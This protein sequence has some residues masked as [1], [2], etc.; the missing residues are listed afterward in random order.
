M[1]YATMLENLTA[2]EEGP[3]AVE[4]LRE[5][6]FIE[7]IIDGKTGASAAKDAGYGIAAQRTPGKLLESPELRERYQEMSM[8]RGITVERVGD[9]IEEL[10]EARANQTLEGKQVTQSEAPDYRVQLKALELHTEL[11]GM[12]DAAKVAGGGSNV[13]L[14]I[15]GP[16]ADR[17]A[18]MLGGE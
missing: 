11:M 12:R 16:A 3:Q 4:S 18:A 8:R 7:G 1:S 13:T 10:L 15:S 9:K 6:R 14:S 5:T 2:K 17:L